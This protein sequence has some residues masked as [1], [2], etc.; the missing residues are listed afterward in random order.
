MA[1]PIA[2]KVVIGRYD[3]TE[4]LFDGSVASERVQLQFLDYKPLPLAFRAMI[5]SDDL[6]VSEMAL[7]THLLAHDHNRPIRG[8]PIPLWRRLHH[9][10]LV[11]RADSTLTGPEEL[12]G[13]AIGVRSYSQTTGVWIRGVLEREYGVD[14]DGVTWVTMEDSHEP[15]FVDPPNARRSRSSRSLRDLLLQDEVVAIMGER[16]PEPDLVRPVIPNA[17]EAERSWQSRTGILPVNHIVAVKSDLLE[18][19]SWLADE[20][21]SLFERARQ[22]S[23]SEWPSYGLESNRDAMQMLMDFSYRQHL[24]RQVYNIDELMC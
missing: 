12:A 2:L 19:H 4:A 16:N 8:L 9:S 23:K 5:R 10:N 7:S 13:C 17:V 6:D 11:C 1:D 20:L 22:A 14:P 21:M 15:S 3:H 18:R 24:T